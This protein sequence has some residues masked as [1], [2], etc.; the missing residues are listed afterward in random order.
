MCVA[1]WIGWGGAVCGGVVWWGVGGLVGGLMEWVGGVVGGLYGHMV[2]LP[3]F[4]R[5]VS[6]FPIMTFMTE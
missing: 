3:S 6:R 5:R 1:V 4:P 2:G